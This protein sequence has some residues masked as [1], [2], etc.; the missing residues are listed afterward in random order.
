MSNIKIKNHKLGK[1]PFIVAEI[2]NNHQGSIQKAYK[3]I[4]SAKNSG[5]T[6]VKFQKRFTRIVYKRIL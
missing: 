5:A 6:A 2:G 4:K 3:L 1:D